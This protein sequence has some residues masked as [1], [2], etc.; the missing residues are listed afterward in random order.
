MLT[1]TIRT[2]N[3]NVSELPE[4]I[5]QMSIGRII[6]DLLEKGLGND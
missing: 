3:P 6:G 5:Q 2:D 1:L 4:D